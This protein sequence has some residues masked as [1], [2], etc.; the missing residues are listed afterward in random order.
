MAEKFTPQYKNPSCESGLGNLSVDGD[1]VYTMIGTD[2]GNTIRLRRM[3][4]Y[5]TYLRIW[6]FFSAAVHANT[7][8]DVG[9]VSR[10]ASEVDDPD[11]FTPGG[12]VDVSGV[13]AIEMFNGVSPIAFKH[14]ISFTI[15]VD[16]ATNADKTI[17][18]RTEFQN[19]SG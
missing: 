7:R 15:T 18:T 5:N 14:D 19:I 3:G 2:A 4:E 13:T 17:T 10:D 6:M 12:P 9:Y 16:E 1:A 11:Y 8:I